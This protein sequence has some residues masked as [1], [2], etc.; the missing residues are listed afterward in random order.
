MTAKEAYNIV[1]EKRKGMYLLECLDFGT[2]F[3]F[4]FCDHKPEDGDFFGGGHYDTVNKS[5]G[6][7]SEF[8]P[9]NDLDTFEN[10][11]KVELNV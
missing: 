9:L 11:E 2:F 7:V 10:A 5:D 6:T 1:I 3:G 8:F 4:L